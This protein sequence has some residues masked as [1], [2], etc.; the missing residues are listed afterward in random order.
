VVLHVHA[1]LRTDAGERRVETMLEFAG[2]LDESPGSAIRDVPFFHA[3]GMLL[4]DGTMRQMTFL[5][6]RGRLTL[7]PVAP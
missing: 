6:A 4:R 1:R 2:G 5:L 7:S 3:P